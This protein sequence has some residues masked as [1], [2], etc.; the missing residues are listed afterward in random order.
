MSE[1]LSQQRDAL[2]LK[3]QNK[4]KIRP[5]KSKFHLLAALTSNEKIVSDNEFKKMK[6]DGKKDLAT[7]GDTVIDY[8]IFERFRDNF[9]D[10]ASISAEDLNHIRENYGNNE[11]L[12]QLSKSSILILMK[13]FSGLKTINVQKLVKPISRVF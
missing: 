11:V 4:F 1:S 3:I 5:F 9:K 13:I 7:I 8:L 6:K 12:H 10:D 2:C